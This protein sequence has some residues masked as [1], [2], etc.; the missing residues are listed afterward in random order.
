VADLVLDRTPT[1]DADLTRVVEAGMTKINIATHLNN[2]FT[3][4]VRD[5]PQVVDTRKYLAP[6][7]RRSRPR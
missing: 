3:T 4:A 6:V 1:A 2:A 7:A 5:N